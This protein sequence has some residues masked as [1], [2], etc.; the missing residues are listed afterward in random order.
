MTSTF[1]LT[2]GEKHKATL[3]SELFNHRLKKTLV[4]MWKLTWVNN[5]NI[6][7]KKSLLLISF[8]KPPLR[9]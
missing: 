9:E 6:D 1:L 2:R 5:V 3:V 8:I 7:E 4:Q